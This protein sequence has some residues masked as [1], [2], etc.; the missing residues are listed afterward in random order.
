MIASRRILLF[1]AAVVPFT[2]ALC[3]RSAEAQTIV[4]DP[5]AV[6]Q[7]LKQVS[8]GLQQIQ[9]L[10]DQLTQQAQMIA[11]LG[12]D[13]TGPLG[14]IAADATGLLKQAQGIGYSAAD[15]GKSFAQM[16]PQDL[17]GMSAKDIAAKLVAWSQSSRQTLQ[18]AMQVQ[19]QIAR[20]Q[21]TTAQAVAT[22]VGASQ[23]ASG[24]T[25]AVQATNQLLA[26]VSSQMTQLQTLLIT[27]ARQVETFEAERRAVFS[28]AE[29][30]RA[31]NSTVIRR[32][33]VFTG[34]TL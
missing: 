28:K 17:S 26:V 10:K 27:Q 25:A 29:A 18:E 22:A 20:S 5:T 8:Q 33:R 14:Q 2:G 13:V 32:P 7:A 24:Q 23:G 19:N 30:D 34:N 12:I 16:Y 9:A 6:A 4:Y 1:A 11:K 3:G 21:P 15:L 31:R